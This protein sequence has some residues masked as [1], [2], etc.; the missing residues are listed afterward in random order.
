MSSAIGVFSTVGYLNCEVSD[1]M[2]RSKGDLNDCCEMDRNAKVGVV[3]QGFISS[4]SDL[5]F[6][7]CV[8]VLINM[9]VY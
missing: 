7:S 8:D 2:E 3:K 5:F 4:S 1:S 9:T 6:V